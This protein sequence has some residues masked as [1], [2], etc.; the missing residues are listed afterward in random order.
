MNLI[1]KHQQGDHVERADNTR[2]VTFIPF[3]EK[4]DPYE[5]LTQEER[6]RAKR[7]GAK[8]AQH[9]R[10]LTTPKHAEVRQTTTEDQARSERIQQV[11]QKYKNHSEESRER[12]KRLAAV[13]GT[14]EYNTVSKEFE[15]ERKAKENQMALTAFGLTGAGMAAAYSPVL[16]ATS[17]VGGKAVDEAVDY[18][19]DGRYKDFADYITDANEFTQAVGSAT[20][21]LPLVG[22]IWGFLNPGYAI[23]AKIPSS[24]KNTLLYLQDQPAFKNWFLRNN[25]YMSGDI[26]RKAHPFNKNVAA[27]ILS[28]IDN[29]RSEIPK[30]ILKTIGVDK[31]KQIQDFAKYLEDLY[32]KGMIDQQQLQVSR[33]QMEEYLSNLLKNAN[34]QFLEIEISTGLPKF[35]FHTTNSTSQT[36]LTQKI[37]MPDILGGETVS[38]Q[39]GT[40]NTTSSFD[41]W[42]WPKLKLNDPGYNTVPRWSGLKI[43]SSSETSTVMGKQAASLQEAH[44]KIQS[45]INK[46]LQGR[47]VVAGSTVD[48]AN[49]IPGVANDLEILTTKNQLKSV[50]ESLGGHDEAMGN[51]L[52]RRVTGSKFGLNG[53]I[54]VDIVE[55]GLTGNAKGKI[56]HQIY[57]ALYD[58]YPELLKK[59]Y[60]NGK[61]LFDNELPITAEDLVKMLQNN[62]N[63]RTYQ[64]TNLLK[65]GKQKHG[66]RAISGF[67]TYDPEI[68]Q[69]IRN[70]EKRLGEQYLPGKYVSAE[71]LN[72]DYSNIEANKLFLKELGFAEE[73]IQQLASNEEAMKAICEK[74][75]MDNLFGRG[76]QDIKKKDLEKAF[77]INTNYEDGR[78]VSGTGGNNI[79]GS[80][81]ASGYS[82]GGFSTIMQ[83]DYSKLG[84]QPGDTPLQFYQKL[85]GNFR[86][87][88]PVNSDMLLKFE[89]EFN[90]I[91]VDI[92]QIKT[93]GG[94]SNALVQYRNN[95]GVQASEQLN[96]KLADEGIIGYNGTAYDNKYYGNLDHNVQ[97]AT[98]TSEPF[99]E[100]SGS[101]LN[102]KGKNLQTTSEY[103]QEFAADTGSLKEV[104][105]KAGITEDVL[106]A[107]LRHMGVTDDAINEFDKVLAEVSKSYKEYI[108]KLDKYRR[109][110]YPRL[111][112]TD[113]VTSEQFS[114]IA[115]KLLDE[116]EHPENI[117]KILDFLSQLKPVAAGVV[118]IGA[119]V[120]PI[121]ANEVVSNEQIK[122]IYPELLTALSKI[123]SQEGYN[124][125]L[126]SI[127]HSALRRLRKDGF[128]HY[129]YKNKDDQQKIIDYINRD[130]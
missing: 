61:P 80:S 30:E 116:H 48:Y 111:K 41:T 24:F 55:S 14:P 17:M 44:A 42:V 9:Y 87:V 115:E 92:K 89:K 86:G 82:D 33:K 72:L 123:E 37:T 4:I 56:A 64:L 94:L 40:R 119:A 63:A 67:T 117:Q 16:F 62:E 32:N 35:D 95:K 3:T 88:S 25:E 124:P 107:S 31:A 109:M 65:S 8:S 19:S 7:M 106:K 53:G 11:D 129:P 15:D 73:Q 38:G 21:D 58:D 34:Q 57:Q 47:G 84:I 103:L 113:I 50:L 105:E 114:Q 127:I 91:G 28:E 97:M 71:S 130:F 69:R 102:R 66:E 76:L 12:M 70:I 2:V 74:F 93:M 77:K 60:G 98:P 128:L 104:A 78:N 6:V 100:S 122:K 110:P 90:D 121:F 23:G 83:K 10:Q 101:F 126:Y 51:G 96:Q 68:I 112:D 29:G 18:F 45:E 1:R 125:E 13:Q 59:W 108:S 49:G 46:L 20:E 79:Y 75:N 5:G 52:G 99:Y 85:Y 54:D 26:Y 43:N 120:S 39:T 27:F 118:G 36:P 22:N 81:G